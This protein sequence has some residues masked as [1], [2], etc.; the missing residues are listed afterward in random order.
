M[1]G[2]IIKLNIVRNWAGNGRP[3][4]FWLRSIT[5][6]KNEIWKIIKD[7]PSY[8]ISNYGRVRRIDN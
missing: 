6:Y 8:E 5:M 2:V 3:S 4:S 7:V 1:T